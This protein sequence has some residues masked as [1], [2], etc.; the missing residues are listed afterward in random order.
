[1]RSVLLG[2]S[3]LVAVGIIGSVMGA[4]PAFA[5]ESGTDTNDGEIVVTAQKRAENV[6]DVP[7]S[8]AAFSEEALR[9]SN[10]IDVRDLQRLVP[11]FTAFRAT[12]AANVR[13]NIRGI[14]AASNTAAEPSVAS[15]ID[16]IYVSRPGAIL[17]NFLDIEAVEV[18]RG[19]QGTLQG[20]NASVGALSLRT[21]APKNEFGAQVSAEAASFG[22][23]KMSGFVNVP[24]SDTVAIRAAALGQTVN[25]IWKNTVDGRTYGAQDDYAG[26]LSMKADITP[27]LTWIVRADYARSTGDGFINSEL[28]G[29]SISAAQLTG[30][31]ARL[32]SFG[33]AAPDL[34]LDNRLVSMR[35]TADLETKQWGVT[36]DLSW[37]LGD[38][39]LRL[40]N[41]YR[42]WRNNQTDG[43]TL[44]LSLAIST[45]FGDYV[46]KGQSHELQIISPEDTLLGGRL[47]YVAGLYYYTEDYTIGENLDLDSQYCNVLVANLAQRAA[48]NTA[49]AAGAGRNAT[50]LSFNQ[51][52][53]SYAGYAQATLK[54]VST[55][56]LTLGT[57]WTRDEKVGQFTQLVNTPFAVTLRA[58][59]N[60][61]LS[62]AD[63]RLTWRASLN[64]KPTEDAM[65]FAN[66]STGFKS[67]GF[68]SGGGVPALG[69]R[70][71]F[72]NETVKNYELGAKTS[73]LGG[74]FT[75][76]ATAF[77]MDIAGFQDRSFDGL[78]FVV[79][80]AGNLR[81]QGVEMDAAIRP[82]RNF[83]LT[84]ALAYL[85]SKFTNY[86][87]ASGL[88]GIGGTRNITG[89][90]NAFS[91]KWQ[92]TFGINW[93]GDI[94]SS[95][96]RWSLTPSLSL[97]SDHY[98]GINDANPQN[99]QDGYVTAQARLAISG[100][101]DR[102]TLAVFGNNLTNANYC[103]ARF[104]Q[105]LGGA[106][107]LNNGVFPGSGAVRC[108][109]AEPRSMGVSGTVRF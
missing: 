21:T 72:A 96:M 23:Y 52:V 11:N 107:G 54:L 48:C 92:G 108:Q 103:Q 84:A 47:S 32:A 64:W 5:Q 79:R 102:W 77:R 19:P 82:S 20:R 106:L 63:D 3:A 8:I 97:I 91:P 27:E 4:T 87:A 18:L 45:R 14:G 25:G 29:T 49:V 101:D 28:L 6:Q 39:T 74:Q 22:R 105:T 55:V 75:L 81:Q 41:G 43:D 73:W 53:K 90:P 36:S 7:I 94:G 13:L 1:M 31:N 10:V 69:Q 86:A 104:Y 70:R 44:S 98:Q 61:P 9:A 78:S 24:L 66:Y 95:G 57:R 68:N 85:D 62:F 89:A 88:P 17:T 2:R 67:G 71:I 80:N 38:H 59:E 51:T 35:V 12:Q 100:P 15:F 60:T 34:V 56:N 30:L 16:D 99:I 37:S 65:L 93:G 26:R 58:A 40:L 33:A 76:N 50:D 46:S 83:S 109:V 42:D